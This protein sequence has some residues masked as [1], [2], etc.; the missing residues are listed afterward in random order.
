MPSARP[1]SAV[2][3][4]LALPGAAAAPAAAQVPVPPAP[5]VVVAPVTVPA[6]PVT[7][8][9]PVPDVFPTVTTAMVPGKVARLRTDGKA[10]V[11]RGAPERVRTLIRHANEIVGKPYVWGGGHARLVDKGYDCSGTVSYALIRTG[12]LGSPLVSGSLARY[13]AAGA[14]RWMTIYAN[15][16]HVY[17]EVAGLRLDTSAVADPNGGD[18]PRWRPV[19][20]KRPGFHVRHVAGL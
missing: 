3:L 2:L 6:T 1:L 5:I 12:L 8:P 10:A 7:P 20:G 17:L 16:D 9:V 11:P 4:A 14:G 18:G 19:I 15:A 13:G